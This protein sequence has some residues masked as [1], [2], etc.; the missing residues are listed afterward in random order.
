MHEIPRI[1]TA[2]S[3]GEPLRHEDWLRLITDAS[4]EDRRFSRDLACRLTQERFGRRVFFRGIIE[5]T[6]YCKN[7]C[8]YC[9]IRRSNRCLS[10]YRLT[11][12]EIL[13][14]CEEGYRLGYRTFVLQGGEDGW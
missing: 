13:S 2:L 14:C 4:E 12:D 5:F 9:G 8:Y 3:A 6:N 1:I 11:E 7:D 10:R